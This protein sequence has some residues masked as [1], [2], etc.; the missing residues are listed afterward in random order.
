MVTINLAGREYPLCFSFTAMKR[1]SERFGS[2]QKMGE[3][4]DRASD[5][6]AAFVDALNDTLKILI[7]AGRIYA[8]HNGMEVPPPLD[9][10][11]AD[12][13]DNSSMGALTA[14]FAAINGD[15]KRTVEVAP[16]KNAE[17]TQ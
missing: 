16:G 3:A 7:E 8:A 6:I 13:L 2:I 17:A 4:L 9:C 10:E 15:S 5:D 11:P 12:L 1:I 14:V